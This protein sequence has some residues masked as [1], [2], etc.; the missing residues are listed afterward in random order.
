MLATPIQQYLD[1]EPILIYG[2]G[3]RGKQVA[4][5]LLD[6]AQEIVG[7]ADAA[8]KGGE[9]W[10]SLPIHRLEDWWDKGLARNVTIVVAIHNCHIDM[11]PLLDWLAHETTGRCINPVQFQTI[12][13]GQF[14]SSYWL[15]GP[16]AYAGQ[17]DNLAALATLLADDGS[18][19]LLRRIVNFR[20]TGNYAALPK[21]TLDDQYCPSDLP[22]WTQP[23]R[24]I[25]AGAFNGDTL[26][27][28]KR[29]GYKFEQIVAF[30]PD[31]ENF[32]HLSRC[33]ENLGSGI[34]LPCGLARTTQQLR[35]AAGGSGASRI[36]D[37]G[38]ML[39]QCVAIDETLPGFRPTLIK[40]DIEGAE[41][42]ALYGATKTI[43]TSR[44]AL[45]ISAYHHPAH[46]WELAFLIDRWRLGYHFHLRM[47]GYNSFDLVLYALP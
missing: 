18:R 16:Q 28:L 34:C 30:E 6:Q 45:A 46:L 44:P 11:V 27:Q 9:T 17:D 13:D 7:F 22:R 24:F 37:S 20:Q 42:D 15:A 31:P 43:A 1:H 32:S 40:M 33:V 5:F 2:A 38:E 21:P 10:R 14:P 36:D 4:A 47:H 35:F 3:R 8:A 23:L 26:Q 39:I 41:P 25:D 19:E 12:F 29:N